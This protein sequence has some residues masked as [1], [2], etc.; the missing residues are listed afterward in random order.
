LLMLSYAR[1]SRSHNACSRS[2]ASG[3]HQ[4]T[5]RSR[6][7]LPSR[8]VD[9]GLGRG[10]ADGRRLLSHVRD[11]GH[12]RRNINRQECSDAA[13]H[14][15]LVISRSRVPLP[16]IGWSAVPPTAAED[17]PSPTHWPATFVT[18][19]SGKGAVPENGGVKLHASATTPCRAVAVFSGVGRVTHTAVTRFSPAAR[20][21]GVAV[22][23]ELGKT[24]LRRP[25]EATFSPPPSHAR[26]RPA[27]VRQKAQRPRLASSGHVAGFWRRRKLRVLLELRK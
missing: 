16:S 3:D 26:L 13:R 22:V 19:T 18:F 14:C 23:K 25:P 21:L 17:Q 15:H 4:M 2:D 24:G 6:P 8:L 9:L 20:P 27:N 12:P 1:Y 5:Q 10:A 11:L 7:S